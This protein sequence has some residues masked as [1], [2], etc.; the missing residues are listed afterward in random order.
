MLSKKKCSLIL[1]VD[2]F[3]LCIL[4]ICNL[5]LVHHRYDSSHRQKK[6]FLDHNQFVSSSI[7]QSTV[8]LPRTV[9]AVATGSL[10]D[11]DQCTMGA[12]FDVAKCRGPQ[13]FKVYV[14]PRE[15]GAQ[16]SELFEFI[17][18]TIQSSPYITSDPKEACL[19]VPSIDTL[20]RDK[21]SRDFVKQLPAFSSLPYWNGGRN[22]LIFVQY[23]GTWPGYSEQLDFSTGQAIL[24]RSSFNISLYR[25]GFDISLP[26]MHKGHPEVRGHSSVLAQGRSNIGLF[27][28]RR[29]YLLGFK[30]K[31]YLYGEG[32]EVRSSVYHLHNNRDILMLTTCRHNKDWIKYVDDRCD[33]DNGLYDRYNVNV[34]HLR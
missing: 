27:P 13:G 30:G 32:S 26:L 15:Q 33:L 34:W 24:A 19:F 4:L 14:Y 21:H 16:R 18:K 10:P 23:S 17:L 2:L 28:I 20:D 22:H 25:D 6:S 1:L 31:R 12:C 8:T 7:S 9:I 5:L 3:C 11:N 29:K